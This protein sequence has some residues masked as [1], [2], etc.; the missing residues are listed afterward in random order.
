MS[1]PKSVYGAAEQLES[2]M[3]E[4]LAT[5][6]SKNA[7]NLTDVDL[8][9]QIGSIIIGYG[10][11]C[12]NKPT[13]TANGYFINI[14]HSSMSNYNKQFYIERTNNRIWTRYQENGTFSEWVMIGAEETNLNSNV[15][16]NRTFN[17]ERVY[18]KT[19]NIG[20]LPNN[21]TK[22]VA[23]GLRPEEIFVLEIRGSADGSDD[24][25]PL[26]NVHP[27]PVN[28]ISCYLRADGKV[29]VA[30]G[31]DRSTMTGRVQIYYIQNT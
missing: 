24:W 13:G 2:E 7:K 14:P 27:N 15:L 19:V 11:G 16:T 3:T 29:V 28:N 22:E 21:T 18:C 17:G 20:N 30:T 4:V 1:Y 5:M 31:K 9:T 25:L 23:S 26:P 12:V 10:N 6:L 8:N